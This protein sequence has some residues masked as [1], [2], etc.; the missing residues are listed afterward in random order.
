MKTI[1]ILVLFLSFSI[2]K[3]QDFATI[4]NMQSNSISNLKII[5]NRLVNLTDKK[6]EFYKEKE[7][8]DNYILVY[9][10]IGL[11]LAQK[12]ESRV[13]RYENGII[14]KLAKTNQGSYKLKEFFAE[15]KI[16]FAIVN[17]VFYPGATQS[18]FLGT[19]KYR[20]YT[21]SAK[22]YNFH[23]YSGDSEK[24]NYRFYS[25]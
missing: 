13:N 9:L 12:E 7:T 23:F 21:D 20:D 8:P 24:S 25:N 1:T 22:G 14:F 10:P 6:F 2:V 15:P 16:M 17:S 19:S 3:A 4:N 5:A 18:D 11:S